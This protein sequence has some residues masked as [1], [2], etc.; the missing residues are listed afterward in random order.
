MK[1]NYELTL[2]SN[3]ITSTTLF[4]VKAGET[5]IFVK[6]IASNSTIVYF[7]CYGNS[8]VSLASGEKLEIDKGWERVIRLNSVHLTSTP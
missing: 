1:C 7:K 2:K 4:D 8:F 3:S 6:D 5:F